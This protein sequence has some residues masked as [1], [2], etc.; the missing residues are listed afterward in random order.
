MRDKTAYKGFTLI[1]LLVVIA[2]ISVLLTVITPALRQARL[3]AQRTICFTNIRGQFVAQYYYATE[4]KGRFAP[5]WD[6]TPN[7]VRNTSIAKS[8]VRR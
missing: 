7:R 5:H 3:Q 8:K 2:I 4:N 1:E 6:F